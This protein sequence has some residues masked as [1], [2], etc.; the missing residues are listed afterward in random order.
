MPSG[1]TR[2]RRSWEK[3]PPQLRGSPQPPN[4]RLRERP[5]V[6][7]TKPPRLVGSRPNPV[8]AST[9]ACSPSNSAP[10]APARTHLAPQT[11]LRTHNHLPRLQPRLAM[12]LTP[13]RRQPHRHPGSKARARSRRPLPELRSEKCTRPLIPR[14]HRGSRTSLAL[15]D[16]GKGRAWSVLGDQHEDR[17][18]LVLGDHREDRAWSVLRDHR[19]DRAPSV[20]R[21]HWK[22]RAQSVPKDSPGVETALLAPRTRR[23]LED[24]LLVWASCLAGRSPEAQS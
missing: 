22:I 7:T 23:N 5:Q 20:P 18:G 12:P 10:N 11:V 1:T 2:P 3:T 16:Q 4:R 24:T 8:P 17:A 19:E 9:A 15:G 21:D 6:P 14:D 13:A